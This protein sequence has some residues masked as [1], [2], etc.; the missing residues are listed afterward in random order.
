MVLELARCLAL[1]ARETRQ[2]LEASLTAL[3]PY[4]Y[5]PFPRNP[6]FTG[7]EEVLKTLRRALCADE[8]VALTQSYA[9]HGLGGIGKTHLAIEYAYRHAP[10]YTAVFWI[11][12]ET[13]ND[14]I[15]SFLAI[16]DLL[17]LPAC[18][19]EN[20]Q[21]IVAAMR[22]WLTNHRGWLLIW[23]NVENLELLQRFLPSARQGAVLITTRLQAL[24]TLARGIE[25]P[26]MTLEEGTLFLLRRAKLL[27]PEMDDA[28]LPL[29]RQRMPDEYT[30]ARK[31][32]AEMDGLP[33]ALDQVG[34]YVEET[35]CSL[36][37]YLELYQTRRAELLKRRGDAVVDHPASVGTTWSLAFERVEH[38]NAAA[39][40]L[41]R[42]C[43]FLHPDAIPE[44]IF[45][46]KIAF[47]GEQP[48]AGEIDTF[49]LH[50]AFRTLAAYSLLK[51][52]P[53][54][55]TLFIHRLV[56]VVFWEKMDEQ[57]RAIWQRRA[58][59]LLNA[60][61][62]EVTYEVWKQCERLLPHVLTCTAA[63]PADVYDRELAEVLRKAAN[64]LRER[65][66]YEQADAL[67]QRA[68]RVWE[69]VMGPEYPELARLLNNLAILYKNQGK[70][71]QAE[72]LFQ[73][74]LHIREQALGP[75]HPELA[76]PLNNLAI[77]YFVRS[78]YERAEPLYLR[79]LRIQERALGPNHPDLAW[80]LNNLANLYQEQGKYEQAQ[81]LYERALHIWEKTLG[82]DHL[83]VACPLYNLAFLFYEQGR[84]EQAE[85]L[86]QRAL[87]ILEQ[88]LGPDHP[89]VARPLDGL[90]LLL[91]AQGKDEQA[92]PLH[93]RALC[94]WEQTLGPNHSDV[95]FSLND[96]A[97]VYCKQGRFAEAI[98]LYQRALAIRE[99][100]PEQHSL[101]TAQ[102]LH[103]LATCYQQQ[104]NPR[105][106]APLYQRALQIRSQFLGDDHP[107]TIATRTCYAQL[108]ESLYGK[109]V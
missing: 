82:A 39:A 53:E 107:K 104:G 30:T 49:R 51:R 98:P 66:Q 45:R 8:T 95:A 67:Y 3:A 73:R 91:Y 2:L 96:L 14:I 89:D 59:R 109:V 52:N 21:Q 54:E 85:P 101:E 103:D 40:S 25:L 24:G 68:L 72:P 16:A 86:Y 18:Q 70:D 11:K 37:D 9:L 12:S 28:R 62:P 88:A 35:P 31:L 48:D 63:I 19:E 79:A 17:H 47:P 65:A 76:S 27:P 84:Y 81:T 99:Q 43:A 42:L 57:E 64:Y 29:F 6:F 33:L 5:V 108:K 74:V 1:D 55:H 22:R 38:T 13:V 44:E 75:D 15:T 7:R 41:L 10:D 97:T 90:A 23:D 69:H 26:T 58:I 100:H 50:K 36:R 102:T 106:A 20:Q 4:W 80:P 105:T 56:Q 77:I 94:I 83:Q 87:R 71:E 78:Q 34:A 32:V 93:L 92:E 61:F 46:E 60:A